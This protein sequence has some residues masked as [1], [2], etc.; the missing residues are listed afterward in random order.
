MQ[1]D[2]LQNTNCRGRFL[3]ISIQKLQIGGRQSLFGG[4]Q[5]TFWRVPIYILAAELVLRVLYRKGVIPK[6]GGT[7][8]SCDLLLSALGESRCCFCIYIYIYIIFFFFLG[9]RAF[10]PYSIQNRPKPKFVQNLSR[11]LFFGVP[12]RGT[13]IC[14]KFVEN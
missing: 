3:Y 8:G 10:L 5:F 12:I 6:K 13:Q 2:A 14:Q 4:C 1:I 7:L 11:R 9:L